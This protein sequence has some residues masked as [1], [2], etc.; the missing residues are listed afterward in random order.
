VVQHVL[1]IGDRHPSNI[2]IKRNGN[3]FH[4]DFGHFL[5][6]TLWLLNI[7]IPIELTTKFSTAVDVYTGC[8]RFIWK[9]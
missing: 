7:I 4:V 8:Q 9:T 3:L 6:A 1:G 5:G 2:M